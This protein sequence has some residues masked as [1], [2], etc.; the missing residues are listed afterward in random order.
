MPEV[1]TQTI[2]RPMPANRSGRL[3]FG[4]G[5]CGCQQDWE[6]PSSYNWAELGCVYDHLPTSVVIAGLASAAISVQPI[7]GYTWFCP[8]AWRVNVRDNVDPQLGREA[9]VLSVTIG[10]CNVYAFPA[11]T[12]PAGGPIPANL[13]YLKASDLDPDGA[14]GCMG[15]P[16]SNWPCFGNTG[17]GCL[18]TINVFNPNPVGVSIR[19]NID[20]MGKGLGGCP[21]WRTVNAAIAAG[22]SAPPM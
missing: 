12:V 9:W 18:L 19:V 3:E 5:A 4:L 21:D 14:F 15:C 2:R 17:Q 20:I 10:R 7:D 13:Q 1:Q 16:T 8:V 6:V 11:A 22:A